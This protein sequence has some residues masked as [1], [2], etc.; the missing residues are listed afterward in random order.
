MLDLTQPWEAHIDER[1]RSDPII[2]LTSTRPDGRPHL[3]TI[4]ER[5]GG[6]D[7]GTRAERKRTGAA[8]GSWRRACRSAPGAPGTSRATPVSAPRPSAAPDSASGH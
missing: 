5:T 3:V 1:L 2:W 7:D 6:G 4:S 8:R